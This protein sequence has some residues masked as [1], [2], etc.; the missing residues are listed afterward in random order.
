MI[1]KLRVLWKMMH[2]R[3]LLLA[4]LYIMWKYLFKCLFKN[5]YSLEILV[6]FVV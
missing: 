2:L 5:E 4:F 3:R 6:H 1:E